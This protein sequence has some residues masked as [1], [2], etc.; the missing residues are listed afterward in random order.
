MKE[1]YLHLV[2]SL[3]MIL[4]LAIAGCIAPPTENS[5]ALGLNNAKGSAANV[6]GTPVYVSEV[7]LADYTPPGTTSSGYSEFLTA[8]PIPADITCRIHQKSMFG[9]NASAFVFN[10][11][12]PPMYINY[13]VVPTNV[14][15]NKVFTDTNTKETK[16]WTYSDY[17]PQSWFEITVRSNTTK[18]I[19]LQDGFGTRKGYST[20]LARTL[21]ILK[22]DDLL[23]EL[24]GNDIKATASVWVKPLG[25]F[26]ESRLAEFTECAYM[27]ERRDT[28]ATPVPT[29]IEGAI[30]TWEPENQ[31]HR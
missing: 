30:Y 27:D 10:L 3:A 11:R 4:L 2:F 1:R 18:E 7:T 5:T 16:T 31:E 14:T 17:S 6:T 9:Y 12:N 8:T 21:K 23:V 28:I 19:Y 15:V 20:Y 24:R 29:T 22:Q 26:E 25:N 13:T